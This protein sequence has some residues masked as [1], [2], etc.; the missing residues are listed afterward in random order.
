MGKNPF[1]FLKLLGKGKCR[2][3][4]SVG[5]P[6]WLSPKGPGKSRGRTIR[7]EHFA[8]KKDFYYKTNTNKIRPG[9]Q[10]HHLEASRKGVGW[11]E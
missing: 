2:L 11:G 4:L 9:L 8:T 10:P 6:I 3:L 7:Q 1:F 5:W